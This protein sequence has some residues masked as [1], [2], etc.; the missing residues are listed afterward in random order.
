M[1]ANQYKVTYINENQEQRVR[2][3]SDLEDVGHCSKELAHIVSVT[4]QL[5]V[6]Q[7]AD[8]DLLLDQAEL[9][10]LVGKKMSRIKALEIQLETLQRKARDLRSKISAEYVRSVR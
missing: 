4:P 9:E 5:V 8:S 2:I 1:Q 7:L 6:D 3:C 10:Y